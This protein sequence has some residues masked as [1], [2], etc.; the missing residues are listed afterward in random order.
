MKRK[1]FPKHVLQS[2]EAAGDMAYDIADEEPEVAFA[3]AYDAVLDQWTEEA[4]NA[5]SKP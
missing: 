1:H 2:A 4:E 3:L 5:R